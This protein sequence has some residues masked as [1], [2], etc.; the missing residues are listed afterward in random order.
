MSIYKKTIIDQIE[1]TRNNHVQVRFGLLLMDN[2]IEID[3]KW[4][5]AVIEPG[6]SVKE[7]ITL[8]NE[9]IVTRPTIRGAPIDPERVNLLESICHMVHTPDVVRRYKSEKEK[10]ERKALEQVGVKDDG[11]SV[12]TR[13]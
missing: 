10:A 11:T 3:C 9:D 1:V 4:H 13:E 6:A 5:R 7:I 2:N 12:P 8:V